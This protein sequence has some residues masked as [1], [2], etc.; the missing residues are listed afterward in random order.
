MN[1]EKYLVDVLGIKKVYL[2]P[3]FIHSQQQAHQKATETPEEVLLKQFDL[4]KNSTAQTLF[5][6]MQD[7]ISET[8]STMLGKMAEAMNWKAAHDLLL[9]PEKLDEDTQNLLIQISLEWLK[10]NN[11]RKLIF[12]TRESKLNENPDFE[13]FINIHHLRV[14]DIPRAISSSQDLKKKTWEQIKI[15]KA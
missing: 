8:E 3:E 13:S 7:E 9:F 10:A 5:L 12:F 1:L 2:D 11:Q 14:C 4:L 15:M 6:I